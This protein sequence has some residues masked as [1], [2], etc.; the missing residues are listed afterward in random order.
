MEVARLITGKEL[1]KIRQ[2]YH[3]SLTEMSEL[4]G[5]S[6]G[7]LCHIEKGRYRLTEDVKRRLIERLELTP[8]KVWRILEV[9]DEFDLK[10]G[11]R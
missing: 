1:K 8:E 5:V 10:K 3:M 9:Y 6:A 11:A 7:H 2:V 4:L